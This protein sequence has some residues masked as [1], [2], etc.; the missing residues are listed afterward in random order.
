MEILFECSDKVAQANVARLIKYLLCRLK[1]TEKEHLLTGATE[2][3]KEKRMDDGKEVVIEHSLPK[4]VCAR[5]INV[6]LYHLKDRAAK[7]WSRFEFYL[8]IIKAFGISSA[9]DVEKELETQGD[10]F[11][12]QSEGARVG[13]EYYFKQNT[14]ER[15]LD[16]ILQDQSPLRQVG[17]K[18]VSMGSSFVSVS[19]TP[20]VKLITIMMSDKG[21]LE[22]YPMSDVVKQMIASKEMLGKMMEP[23]GSSDSSK[24]VI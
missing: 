6:L 24:E 15:L 21:L 7:S 23:S 22:K 19:F 8:D 9:E 18:R 16:F 20:I 5:W 13:L 1:I 4:A 10:V 11:D 2:I 14:L 17:E 12:L 3:F